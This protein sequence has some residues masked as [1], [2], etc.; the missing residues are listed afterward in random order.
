MWTIAKSLL[1][2][3]GPRAPTAIHGASG[4]KFHPFE[5]ANTIA[6]CLKFSSRHIICVTITIN[7][8][9]RL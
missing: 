1:E 7:V 4:F 3:D 5:K 9:W 8:R 6:D 2:R